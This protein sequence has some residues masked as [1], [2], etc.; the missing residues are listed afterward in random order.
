MSVFWILGGRRLRR[1]LIKITSAVIIIT[2][3]ITGTTIAATG[4]ALLFRAPE[5]VGVEMVVADDTIVEGL[6]IEGIGLGR[7]VEE[8]VIDETPKVVGA[9]KG[10]AGVKGV[11]WF[12]INGA[13][14]VSIIKLPRG[15]C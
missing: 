10:I 3:L 1:L 5:T 4:T 9:V 15:R 13:E 14:L 11:A 12:P 8:V 7:F 6:V 2:P